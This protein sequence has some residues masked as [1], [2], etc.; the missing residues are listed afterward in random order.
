MKPKTF[1]DFA[2]LAKKKISSANKVDF[3]DRNID[4]Y[5]RE[6]VAVDLASCLPGIDKTGKI[7]LDVGCGCDLISELVNEFMYEDDLLLLVDSREMLKNVNLDYEKCLIKKL[8]GKFPNVPKLFKEYTGKVDYIICNSVI[9]Y[10]LQEKDGYFEFIDRALSLLK[11]GGYLLIS[12]IPNKSKARRFFSTKEGVKYH[13][14]KNKTKTKPIVKID[15]NK[16]IDDYDIVAI[17]SGYREQGYD[18]YLLPMSSDLEFSNRR[19]HILIR[20]Y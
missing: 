13:Q 5:M 17:L 10:V 6:K 12:D 11:S 2:S 19:E 3:P 4:I 16:D 14:K 15:T 20:K 7:V 9:Q 8:P 18:T 1:N